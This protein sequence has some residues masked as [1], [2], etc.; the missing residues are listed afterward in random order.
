VFH[1]RLFKETNVCS[2]R[3]I[4][5]PLVNSQSVGSDWEH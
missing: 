1:Q 3:P 2:R 5:P 4:I